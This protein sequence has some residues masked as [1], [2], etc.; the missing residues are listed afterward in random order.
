MKRPLRTKC[1]CHVCRIYYFDKADM[2]GCS[3][4]DIVVVVRI[5]LLIIYWVFSSRREHITGCFLAALSHPVLHLVPARRGR[6]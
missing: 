3:I 4:S 6:E 1:G 5:R 2:T